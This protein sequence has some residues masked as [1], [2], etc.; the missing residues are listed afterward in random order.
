MNPP[1]LPSI[2]LRRRHNQKAAKSTQG[3]KIQK[4]KLKVHTSYFP[5]TILPS[6]IAV[7][8]GNSNGQA[9][10][11]MRRLHSLIIL[12]VPSIKVHCRCH[13]GSN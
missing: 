10:G 2:L 13:M 1:R 7:F 3:M 4:S 5:T 11:R 9:D 12:L 8:L 6:L